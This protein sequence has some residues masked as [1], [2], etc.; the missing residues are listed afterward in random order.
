MS[1]VSSNIDT[2][3]VSHTHLQAVTNTHTATCCLYLSG[4]QMHTHA[5]TAQSLSPSPRIAEDTALDK[6]IHESVSDQI[7]RKS[8]WR[9]D[10]S[11]Y[12][13]L[14]STINILKWH[15]TIRFP[16]QGVFKGFIINLVMVNE[17]FISP[18]VSDGNAFSPAM[19]V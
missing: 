18:Y 3:R 8:T 14:L 16:L 13:L 1:L 6:N 4:E 19:S 12:I 15:F 10:F 11:Y 17:S 2:H 7:E 5:H 9:V